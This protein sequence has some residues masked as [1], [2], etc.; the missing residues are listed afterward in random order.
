METYEKLG[1]KRK[2][3]LWTDNISRWIG[4]NFI[5]NLLKQHQSNLEELNKIL[6]VFNKSVVFCTKYDIPLSFG[7]VRPIA[8]DELYRIIKFE[9][10]SGL[11]NLNVDYQRGIYNAPQLLEKL[12]ELVQERLIY[13][14]YFKIDNNY[15]IDTRDYI[16]ERLKQL[17]S[18]FISE[19]Q[20]NAGGNWKGESWNSSLPRDSDVFQHCSY[21]FI[22]YFVDFLYYDFSLFLL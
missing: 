21:F 16:I 10:G 9:N 6:S 17:Q 3:P 13:E 4:Y 19:Y 14:K 22:D 8:W 12:K 20:N 15:R 1:I 11:I 7:I 5:P 18:N 2:I